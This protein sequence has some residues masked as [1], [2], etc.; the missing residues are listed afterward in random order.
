[1]AHECPECG[2]NCH[3]GGDIDDLR[4]NSDKYVNQCTHC[5]HN[6]DWEYDEFCDEYD[7][8]VDCPRCRGAGEV[9]TADHESYFGTQMKPCPECH[10][11]LDGLGNGPLS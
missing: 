6:Y 8:T 9:P 5:D 1:M 7:P 3:C 4:L 10:G 11:R 2:L